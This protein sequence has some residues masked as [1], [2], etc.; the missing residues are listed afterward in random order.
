MMDEYIKMCK[1]ATEIQGAWKPK[2]GDY[3][4]NPYPSIRAKSQIDVLIRAFK[5]EDEFKFKRALLKEDGSYLGVTTVET[6]LPLKKRFAWLPRQEDL[7]EIIV[8]EYEHLGLK[9]YQRA[10]KGYEYMRLMDGFFMW[11]NSTNNDLFEQSIDTMWLRFTMEEVY[12]K[13]WNGKTWVKI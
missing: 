10:E 7:Q 4:Y 3:V 13:Q 5:E 12:N 2:P 1:E 9:F 11:Y 8:N 6:E